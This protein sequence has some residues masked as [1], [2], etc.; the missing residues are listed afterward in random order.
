MRRA[1]NTTETGVI[2]LKKNEMEKLSLKID[3]KIQSLEM[4]YKKSLNDV[5]NP[6]LINFNSLI[7]EINSDVIENV[8]QISREFGKSGID[9]ELVPLEIDFE[10]TKTSMNLSFLD[11]SDEKIEIRRVQATSTFSGARRWLGGFFRNKLNYENDWGYEEERTIYLEL[12][13]E[14]IYQQL[15]KQLSKELVQP[16]QTHLEQCFQAFNIHLEDDLRHINLQIEELIN[17]LQSAFDAEQLPYEEKKKRKDLMN[18]IDRSNKSIQVEINTIRKYLP[19]ALG[20][21]L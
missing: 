2:K 17:E 4:G 11:L 14:K 18:D 12:K 3:R 1:F 9:I 19:V 20:Y 6:I 8:S 7:S 21:A 5:L 10:N 15:D 13:I 16:L